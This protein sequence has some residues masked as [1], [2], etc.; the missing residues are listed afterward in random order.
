MVYESMFFAASDGSAPC[1]GDYSP[2][3]HWALAHEFIEDDNS[4]SFKMIRRYLG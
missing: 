1:E 2:R 3:P 4:V